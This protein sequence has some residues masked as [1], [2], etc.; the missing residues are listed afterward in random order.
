MTN[1]S[2]PAEQK[3]SL[4]RDF[5][6]N[7]NWSAFTHIH[8]IH[9]VYKARFNVADGFSPWIRVHAKRLSPLLAPRIVKVDFM[10]QSK[11]IFSGKPD[12]VLILGWEK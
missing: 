7:V 10:L 9:Y 4:C 3:R 1:R 8:T 12:Q 6:L 11:V 2:L 5:R